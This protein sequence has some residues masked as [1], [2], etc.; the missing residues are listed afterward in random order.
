MYNKNMDYRKFIEYITYAAKAHQENLGEF[1]KKRRKLSNGSENPYI[2]HPLWCAMMIVLEPKL[3]EKTRV[4]GAYALLFHDVL[5]D[6]TLPLPADLP[7]NIKLLVQKMTVPKEAQYN[8]SGWEKE[9]QTILKLPVSIQLLKLYD[10]TATLYDEALKEERFP[11][12]MD[13]VEKLA[14]NVQKEYGKL[15]IVS[16][17]QA[18]IQ[19]KRQELSLQ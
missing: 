13:V 12:W 6:T 3:D 18:I 4:A 15:R 14:Q 1:G 11:E 10:K 19:Q 17:A 2:T 9:K 16:L 7:E 5:E 8:F